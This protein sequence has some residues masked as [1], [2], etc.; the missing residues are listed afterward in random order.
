MS[1]MDERQFNER[2]GPILDGLD[3]IAKDLRG[4]TYPGVAWQ[5]PRKQVRRWTL[6]LWPAAA[7]AV[8]AAVLL[9]MFLLVPPASN[10]PDGQLARAV[11][12]PQEDDL[13]VMEMLIR[14]TPVPASNPSSDDLWLL[15]DP[16]LNDAPTSNQG[17]S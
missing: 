2:Y 6:V 12:E 8:A 10:A 4:Q 9:A 17:A 11:L 1:D 15:D 5:A 7:A 16:L 3:S 13:L 14:E